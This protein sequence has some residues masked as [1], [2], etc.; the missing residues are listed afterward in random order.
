MRLLLAARLSKDRAGQTGLDSQDTDARAWAERSGHEVIATAADKISGRTSP[1]DRPNLGLWLT[2]PAL[3]VKY[4]GIVV[5]KLDRLSRGR[6]WGIRSWAEE[7][8][9]KLIVVSPELCWPPE[10]GDTATPI[11]WDSLVNIASA[12]WENTSAR[13]RR[14]MVYLKDVKS[15]VGRPPFGYRVSGDAKAKTLVLHPEESE[16]LRT[17]VLM[18]LEGRSLRYLCAY[19]DGAGMPPPNSERWAPKSLAQLLRNPVLMGRRTDESGRTVLRV[20][21][22]LDLDTWRKLQAEMDRKAARKGVAPGNTAMLIGVAV[23][24]KCGG[25]M[26]RLNCGRKRKDGSRRDYFYYRCHGTA[27]EPSMCRNLY[28]VEELE[29]RVEKFMT[30]TLARWPRYEIVTTP[31]HGH[32]EE[33]YEVERDLRELDFDDPGF[34]EKQAAL[35]AERARLRALP[36]VPPTVERRP[37]GDTVGEF[38]A[39]LKTDADKRAFLMSL[40]MTIRVQRGRKS[41]DPFEDDLQDVVSFEVFGAGADLQQFLGDE[42]H[43]Q[44]DGEA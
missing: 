34:T 18:Y 14:M 39:T 32:E 19:L 20:P 27:A 2:D 38:W 4:D 13:Y 30:V 7:H 6:D 44:A 1:F 36:S 15:L 31:G 43:L 12:E 25:P 40:G 9:K 42:L 5:S 22:L 41:G 29:T 11:V 35:L 3:M 33:I 28:P 23:C 26:F 16:A 24:L 10:P 17:V 37:T 21:P 8:D